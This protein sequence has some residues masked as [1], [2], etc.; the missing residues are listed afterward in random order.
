MATAR[1]NKHIP[2]S[3]QRHD[4]K[5]YALPVGYPETAAI[6]GKLGCEEPARVWLTKIEQAAFKR[7]VRLFNIRANAVKL[8]V[9]DDLISN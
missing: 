1:C 8:R 3:I 7:G 9:S 5:T 4:Y 6:C 2:K